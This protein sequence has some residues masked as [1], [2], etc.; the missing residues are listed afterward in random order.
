MYNQDKQQFLLKSSTDDVFNF[1]VDSSNNLCYSSLNKKLVWSKPIVIKKQIHPCF[2][3]DIDSKDKIHIIFQNLDGDIFYTFINSRSIKTMQILKSKTSS[4][5]NKYLRLIPSKD[6]VHFFYI[7]HHKNSMILSHQ[8]L[9]HTTL[10]NPQIIASSSKNIYPYSVVSSDIG[11]IYL[12]YNFFDGKVFQLGYKI[13]SPFEAMWTKFSQITNS[14]SDILLLDALID[15]SDFIHILYKEKINKN[16]YKFYYAK[17]VDDKTKNVIPVIPASNP[18]LALLQKSLIIFGVKNNIIYFTRSDDSGLTW[19]NVEKC[20]MNNDFFCVGFSKSNSS[21]V[22]KLPISFSNGYTIASF[23]NISLNLNNVSSISSNDFKTIV[24]ESLNLLKNKFETLNQEVANLKLL[25]KKL[26]KKSAST[27]TPKRLDYMNNNLLDT[28]AEYEKF[29][30]ELKSSYGCDI[31]SN[32]NINKYSSNIIKKNKTKKNY[33]S[34]KK[35][36]NKKFKKAS[37]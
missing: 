29:L 36:H 21:T 15:S 37:D 13:Y 24:L 9:K 2:Y 18:T 17:L 27:T 14:N 7:L 4:S 23:N 19:S 8:I 34:I 28:Q 31:S 30:K 33:V 25:Y 16:S 10:S 22:M 6:S 35:L 32:Y 20:T 11:N 5:Y 3:A 26:E 1:F 12:Y